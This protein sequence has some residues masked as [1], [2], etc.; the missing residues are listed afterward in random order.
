MILVNVSKNR[1]TFDHFL[2][3]ATWLPEFMQQLGTK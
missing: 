2:Y 3:S 1:W